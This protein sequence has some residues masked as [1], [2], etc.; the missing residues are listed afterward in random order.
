VYPGMPPTYHGG[1]YASLYASLCSLPGY[2]MQHTRTQYRQPS[3]PR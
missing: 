3:T 2:T 1:I